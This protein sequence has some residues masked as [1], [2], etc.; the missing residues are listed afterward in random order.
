MDLVS[1]SQIMYLYELVFMCS[2]YSYHDAYTVH[3]TVYQLYHLFCFL[4]SIIL[5]ILNPSGYLS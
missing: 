5:F 2:C 3:I 1:C 4:L